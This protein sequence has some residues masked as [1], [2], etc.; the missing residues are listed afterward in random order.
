MPPSPVLQDHNLC[1]MVAGVRMGRLVLGGLCCHWGACCC[2]QV[3]GRRQGSHGEL[4]VGHLVE[5]LACVEV[6]PTPLV[7]Q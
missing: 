2:F 1:H 3:G 5:D 7:G 4:V 6:E